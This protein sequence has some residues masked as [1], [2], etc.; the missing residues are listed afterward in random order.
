[1]APIEDQKM[2][3]VDGRPLNPIQ[4]IRLDHQ[5]LRVGLQGKASIYIY[6]FNIDMLTR[7]PSMRKG[8]DEYVLQGPYLGLYA[9]C[10]DDPREP[11]FVN[12]HIDQLEVEV[13]YTSEHE[14]LIKIKGSADISNS[15]IDSYW[16][17]GATSGSWTFMV[18]FVQA[19]P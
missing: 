3:M 1:M 18:S 7:A 2:A 10:P 6:A 15:F 11:A 12:H 16:Y 17:R 9:D 14:A 8:T 19:L 5:G 4:S 13:S